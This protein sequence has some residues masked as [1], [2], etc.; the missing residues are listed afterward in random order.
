[1]GV[2]YD[3]LKDPVE[4][5]KAYRKAIE[6]NPEYFEAYFNLAAIFYNKGAESQNAASNIPPK[7]NKKYDAK[8]KE[9]KEFYKESLPFFEKAHE[10]KPKDRDAMLNLKEIYTKTQQYEKS[11]AIK[12]ELDALD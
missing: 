8:I 7:E 10:I 1:M 4:A 6:I 2:S 3:L 11:K 5:E 12:E 9:A